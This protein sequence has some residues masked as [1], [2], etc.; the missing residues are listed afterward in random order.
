[1]STFDYSNE[2]N[3]ALMA[4]DLRK[5]S[6]SEQGANLSPETTGSGIST[7]I[8]FPGDS[9][10]LPIEYDWLR[11]FGMPV[12]WEKGDLWCG[13]QDLSLIKNLAVSSNLCIFVCTADLIEACF[14]LKE[15]ARIVGASED[16]LN[17]LRDYGQPVKSIDRVDLGELLSKASDFKVRFKEEPLS[18][19]KKV[20]EQQV[21]SIRNLIPQPA[22]EH[23]SSDQ[24]TSFDK[25]S[26]NGPL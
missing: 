23:S 1:M 18:P 9:C 16:F 10:K 25:R 22:S 17:K 7:L 14:L 6:P 8:L 19:S 15:D 13:L 4:Q 21:E 11:S 26:E 2:E 24:D 12:S 20:F 3:E 5:T